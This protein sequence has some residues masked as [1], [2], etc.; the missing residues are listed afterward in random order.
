M[1]VHQEPLPSLWQR[2][3]CEPDSQQQFCFTIKTGVC[4]S[5]NDRKGMK[6]V[7][8][9]AVV[10]VGARNQGSS[11]DCVQSRGRAEGSPASLLQEPLECVEVAGRSPLERIL[12]RFAAVN[13]EAISVLVES[14]AFLP[15]F[16]NDYR[17]VR[18][19]VAS[20]LGTAVRQEFSAYCQQGIEHAFV[21]WT[22]SYV[23]T[24]LLDLF[25]FHRE[26]RQ[27]ATPTFD[28][29]GPLALWVVDCAKAQD[30]PTEKRLRGAGANTASEYFIREYVNRLDHPRDL[31]QFASDMLR[32]RCRTGPHGREV[33]PG[34]WLDEGAEIHRRA[35]LVAPAYIGCDSKVRADALI[36][37]FSNIERDCCVDCGTVVEDSSVL[38]NTSVGIWL[39]LCHAVVSGNMLLNLERQVLIEILDPRVLRP[40]GATRKFVPKTSERPE[41]RPEILEQVSNL[42]EKRP[43][44]DA[45]QFSNNNL[46]QE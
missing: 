45:W 21:N 5:G 38:E 35:R 6:S 17:N 41:I 27:A 25:S 30:L 37:R 12:E 1:P 20:D 23:E 11:Q 34:V 33:R 28:Q 19:R 44:A 46:I 26:A 7:G 29:Q 14:E 2:V 13:L 42:Q 16:R 9:G 15:A 39:D 22:S 31:R 24:D 40:T 18:F 43:M 3:R 4:K 36:T 32:G 10:V 8:L